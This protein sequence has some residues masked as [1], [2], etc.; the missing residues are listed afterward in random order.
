LS[1]DYFGLQDKIKIVECNFNEPFAVHNLMNR[2]K[3]IDEIYN[4]AAISFVH[5]SFQQPINTF[6]TNLDPVLNF[7][8]IIRTQKL[9]I[10]FYQAS[11]SEMYGDK[12]SG[13]LNENSPMRP[14]SPYAVAKLASYN[15]V[16]LYREAYSIHATNGILFNHESPLRSDV[17][18]T[19]KITKSL[20][21][22]VNGKKRDNSIGNIYSK[23]DWGFAGDYVKGMYEINN[24]NIPDDYVIATGKTTTVK[25][26][27]NLVAKYLKVNI[28]WIE[29]SPLDTKCIDKKNG[30]ILFKTNKYF[31]RPVD[32]NYLL[33]DYSKAKNKLKWK[34]QVDLDEMI[35]LMC[36]YDLK[37]SS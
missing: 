27:I 17:F 18:V 14:S 31:F 36:E 8:E 23:R 10:K 12:N 33:G 30:K 20:C 7:L 37:E 29:N 32:V 11:T 25:N 9:D 21:R 5:S 2:F 26:F 4:L 19:R 1:F 15:L 34:P 6:K 35:G 16:K 24:H 3:K 22:Y 28:E 13:K